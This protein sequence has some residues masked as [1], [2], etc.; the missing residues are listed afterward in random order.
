MTG[1]LR[2]IKNESLRELFSKGPNYREPKPNDFDDCFKVISDGVES[3][4]EYMA[5]L[6]KVDPVDFNPW[7]NMILSKVTQLITTLKPKI[8]NFYTKTVLKQLC[9]APFLYSC[10]INDLTTDHCAL[11]VLI[12]V[13]D[14]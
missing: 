4:A 5:E 10:L 11:P 8:R 3:C 7:V 6:M 12:T 13:C 9:L 2:I 14:F 1:D